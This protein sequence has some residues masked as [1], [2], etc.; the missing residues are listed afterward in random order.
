MSTA[1]FGSITDVAGV[2]VGHHQRAGRGWQTGTTVVFV[3]DG[4][5]PGVS[6]RGGGPGT[7]ETDALRPENLVELIHA[8][9][10]TGGSA[11]GLAAADGVVGWLEEQRLGFPVG[12]PSN[13]AVEPVG[14]VPVVPAAVVF[15]LG[16]GGDF[17]N[18]PDAQFGKR[19][20]ERAH[21]RHGAQGS[22]GSVGAGTGARA[23]GLQGGV[24]TAGTIVTI[25]GDIIGTPGVDAHVSVGAVA[26]VNANGSP[27][28]PSSGLPWT[29]LAPVAGLVLR[30]PSTADRA[31]LRAAL[32][33]QSAGETSLNTTIG[34]VATSATLT[35]SEVSK[36]ADVAHDGLARA[37][38]PAHSMF[39][40]DTVFGLATGTVDLG[41]GPAA[42]RSPA[43]RQRAVNQL[44]TAAADTF[45]LACVHAVIAAERRGALA[46]YADLCPSAFRL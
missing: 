7:R 2:R 20:V 32:D 9:C 5:T 23:G 45:E 17:A 40:G 39:D 28:D 29:H 42:M 3:P 8:V 27:I 33:G 12:P 13:A 6:V 15:D 21:G 34:V 25:A 46:S 44:L 36:M 4:A 1:P 11:F 18:R 22:W 41:H 43:S 26:V 16:R 37:I 31:R 30:L 19:A 24:G 14:V 38:R 10:L 35:K